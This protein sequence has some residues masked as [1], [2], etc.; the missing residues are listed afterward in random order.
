M[1]T[2]PNSPSARLNDSPAPVRIDGQ[3]TGSVTRRNVVQAPA[4]SVAAASSSARSSSI[5]T[6][7]TL[8]ITN[9]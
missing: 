9:G 5:R 8:R 4:P 2:L 7:C 1:T 6:G 3:S